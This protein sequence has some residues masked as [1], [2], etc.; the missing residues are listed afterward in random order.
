MPECQLCGETEEE[1]YRCKKCKSMFCE[2]CGSPEDKACIDCLDSEEEDSEEDD[3][4]SYVEDADDTF[5]EKKVVPRAQ[6]LR[7]FM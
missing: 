2:Y 5:Y 4:F 1:L 3:D 7:D 6:V